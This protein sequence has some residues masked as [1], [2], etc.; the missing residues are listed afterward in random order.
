LL[1]DGLFF[2][3]LSLNKGSSFLWY[4]SIN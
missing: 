4:A 2:D 3:M 1:H